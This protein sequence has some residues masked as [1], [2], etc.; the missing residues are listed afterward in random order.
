MNSFYVWNNLQ[1]IPLDGF[2]WYFYK[3]RKLALTKHYYVPI[4]RPRNSKFGYDDVIKIIREVRENQDRNSV[5]V[6][7][8]SHDDM[9]GDRNKDTL[10]NTCSLLV[11]EIQLYTNAKILFI[12]FFPLP[13]DYQDIINQSIRFQGRLRQRI[14]NIPNVFFKINNSIPGSTLR[15]D[16]KQRSNFVLQFYQEIIIKLTEITLVRK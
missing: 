5:H 6:I 13:L 10:Y 9:K 2:P 4:I 16:Q 1:L 11:D 7:L 15:L 8:L 12:G 14:K 3:R